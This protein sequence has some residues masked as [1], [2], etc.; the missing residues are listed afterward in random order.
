MKIISIVGARPQF[1]K[2]GVVSKAIQKRSGIIEKIIHTG[3]HFD[4]N[5]SDI[6]FRQ[7]KIPT[8]DYQ[9]SINGLSHGEMTGKMLIE[10]E[11][12]FLF[13]R[14]DYVMVYGDTNSTLSGALAASKIHIPVIH[15]EAGLRS[16]NM[17]MPEEINRIITDQISTI[18]FCPTEQAIT[19]LK[20]EGFRRRNTDFILVGDVMLDATLDF[21]N[22]A[23]QPKNLPLLKN[24][25]LATCHRQENTDNPENLRKIINA[26]NQVH[27]NIAPLFCPLHPIQ[28]QK[29][30]KI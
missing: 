25:I 20:D 12:I 7:L 18:L 2:A 8:P 15:V 16:F 6:F 5:M 28:Y 14:P 9:L 11:K 10:L 24:F 4:L 21:K 3:Q 27:E 13:E 19:N 17:S 30:W 26:L 1:I 23:I 29:L 22:A